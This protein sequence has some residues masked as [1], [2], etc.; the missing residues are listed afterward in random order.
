MK[1]FFSKGACSLAV[2]IMIN[3]IGVDSAYESVNLRNKTT[4]SGA[5]FLAINPKGGVPT[6]ALE[7]GDILTEN[8]I[9]LQY[10]CD[11]SKATQL[12]APVG[13]MNRY[14]ALE[15]LN[16]VSTEL[17]KGMGIMFNPAITQALKNDV[18]IPVVQKKL[19]Y[20]NHHLEHHQYLM[21]DQLTIADPYLF[22]MLLW[23]PHFNIDLKDWPHLSR[24]FDTLKQ[25]ESI[26]CALQ[27]EGL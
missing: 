4:A 22:V 17:H 21:G 26:Q 24:Y 7:N 6:L 15:W 10:L 8:A 14:R 16:F 27:Q 12:L 5:D 3:E 20:V 25:R 19:G 18:F 23:T 13:N 9:I 2:R 1:L 11:Q